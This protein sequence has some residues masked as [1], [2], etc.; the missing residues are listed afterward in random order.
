MTRRAGVLIGT[1]MLV[2]VLFGVLP[3]SASAGKGG[4]CKGKDCEI[5][6]VPWTLIL[7]G[8]GAAMAGGYYVLN[9]FLSRGDG[10]SSEDEQ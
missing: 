5:P 9:R 3:S 1:F 8:A 6:E 10:D 4:G 7:P 2:V